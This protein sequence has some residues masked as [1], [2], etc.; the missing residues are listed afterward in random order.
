LSQPVLFIILATLICV[1]LGL[2]ILNRL[3]MDIAALIMALLLAG[4]QLTGLGILG[5]SHNP[6]DVVKAISGFSQP[7]V[8][9]LLSLFIL[10]R[11]L[12]KSGITRWIAH[13]LIRLGGNSERNLIALFALTTALLSLF[14]NNLAAGAMVLP[15]AMEV[16][17]RTGIKPSKLLIPVAF[18]SLLGGTATYLTTANI[19]VSG[20]LQ[21][22]KPPQAPL[23]VLDFTP[24]GGLIVIA[25]IIFFWLFGKYLLPDRNP[26]EVQAL[27]RLT[28]S[29][30]EDLYHLDERLW[31]AYVPSNSDFIGKDLV[32][33]GIGRNWGITVAAVRRGNDNIL[34]PGQFAEIMAGD[35]LII[36]GR[37]EKVNA[38]R[39]TDLE[40]QHPVKN[41]HLSA[42]GVTF[43]EVILSPHSKVNGQT[44]KQIEFRK[45]YGLTVVALQRLDR[46]YRTDVGDIPLSLGDS[47]LVIGTSDQIKALKQSIHFIVI[48]PNPSDQPINRRASIQSAA[49]M[50]IAIAAAIAGVPI[51]LS[52]LAGALLVVLL[53]ILSMDEA[54]RAIEWQAI[55]LIAGMYAVS[56]AMVNTG[57]AAYLGNAMIN[58][59]QPLGSIGIAAGSFILTAVL[60]QFMGGQVTALVTGPIA[61]SAAIS[62]G[63]VPQGVAVATAI[64]CS[65][66]FLTPLA[67]PVNIL[68]IAPANY[69]FSDFFNIGW[70]LTILSFLM[71]LI[72]LKLFW[73]M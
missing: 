49:V 63:V 31:E 54:Y 64:A 66:S 13:Q 30:L 9:T 11:A 48:E 53:G 47:L 33:S 41:G 67:H 29:E 72:G 20:L 21:I 35:E 37:E 42:Q 69:K 43:Y 65:A 1:P 2:V 61:I 73:G 71:L 39:K 55:F 60:T 18:G 45:H 22:A 70:I 32:A 16:A 44:L 36:V 46:I 14:M 23:N 12:D 38:L 7:V 34:L 57:L 40:I 17:R 19:I 26:T 56:L 27:A 24:T 5:P 8:I 10:T 25:G 59:V 68:M 58:L 15:S 6:G 51:Y 4:L 28:G 52:M 62:M 3:R 50:V